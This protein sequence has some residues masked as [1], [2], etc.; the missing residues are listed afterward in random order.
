MSRY[1]HVLT[2]GPVMPTMDLHAIEPP[3]G[4][5]T[6]PTR[7]TSSAVALVVE[8][9][10]ESTIGDKTV[11]W[12]KNDCFTLPQWT[13]ISH[14]GATGN[15]RLFLNSDRALLEKHDYLREEFQ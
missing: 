4:A 11:R 8:G 1:T 14:R 9:E 3:R 10:G 13:W 7:S 2:G 12:K 6:R 15:A 5:E